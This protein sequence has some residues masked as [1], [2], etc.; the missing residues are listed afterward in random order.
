MDTSLRMVAAGIPVFQ[1]KERTTVYVAASDSFTHGDPKK[2]E[3]ELFYLKRIFSKPVLSK[4]LPNKEKR[5]LLSMCYFHLSKSAFYSKNYRI[6]LLYSMKSYFLYPKGYNEKTNKIM[7]V[8]LV[9]GFPLFGTV[10]R[11]IKNGF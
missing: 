11:R 4:H 5:R 7:F 9:Y 2:W 8:S 6:Q 3:K 1:I 10:I